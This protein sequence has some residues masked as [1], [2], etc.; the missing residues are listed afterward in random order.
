MRCKCQ[1]PGALNTDAVIEQVIKTIDGQ[2]KVLFSVIPKHARGGAV[3]D[4]VSTPL[5]IHSSTPREV[6]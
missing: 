6:N 5:L 1:A 3:R 2:V 4:H